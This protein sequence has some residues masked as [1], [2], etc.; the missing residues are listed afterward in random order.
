MCPEE[1]EFDFGESDK[2]CDDFLKAIED[3]ALDSEAEEASATKRTVT[4]T[5]SQTTIKLPSLGT[6][7]A[8]VFQLKVKPSPLERTLVTEVEACRFGVLA[9]GP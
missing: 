3:E 9:C 2:D 5:L 6:A 8:A 4:C 1:E 7:I